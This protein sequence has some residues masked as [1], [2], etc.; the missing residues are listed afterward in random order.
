M[1]SDQSLCGP[2]AGDINVSSP[3][4]KGHYIETLKSKR[5]NIFIYTHPEN[6]K[7]TI[8]HIPRRRCV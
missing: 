4:D 2:S 3:D 8:W 6:S 7:F 1:K 5:L